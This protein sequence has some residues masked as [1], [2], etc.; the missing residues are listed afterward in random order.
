MRS[1]LDGETLSR[2]QPLVSARS[3]RR[4]RGQE[5][6]KGAWGASQVPRRRVED[7]ILFGEPGRQTASFVEGALTGVGGLEDGARKGGGSRRLLGGGRL[8]FWISK[9]VALGIEVSR[10][11][12]ND[13]VGGEGEA[14]RALKP[15]GARS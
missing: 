4:G 12:C 1:N 5:V 6:G 7:G 3:T 15:A 11:R 14:G 2:Q 10:V 8:C 9:A 13:Q